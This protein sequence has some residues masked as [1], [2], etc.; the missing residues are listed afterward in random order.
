MDKSVCGDEEIFVL[1]NIFMDDLTVILIR[2]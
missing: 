2:Q 1:F